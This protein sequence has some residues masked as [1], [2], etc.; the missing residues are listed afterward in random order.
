VDVLDLGPRAGPL[1]GLVA[2]PEALGDDAFQ[3]L[4]LAGLQHRLAIADHRGRRLPIVGLQA[5]SLELFAPLLGW[6]V[7][8]RVAIKVEHVENHVGDRHA[9]SRH[10][11]VAAF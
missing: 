1:G 7:Q 10:G 9:R 8:Q 11:V 4:L 2:A 6:L 3:A 5:E